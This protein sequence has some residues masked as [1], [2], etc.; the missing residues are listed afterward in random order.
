MEGISIVSRLRAMDVGQMI[1]F[2]ARQTRSVRNI[3]YD[4]LIEERIEGRTW[5]TKIDWDSK[6]VQ[7]TRVS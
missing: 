2:P 1:T 7:V 5:T 3:I 6:Q 4:R